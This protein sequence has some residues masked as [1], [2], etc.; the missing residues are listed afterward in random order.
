MFVF[1]PEETF[2]DK[3]VLPDDIYLARTGAIEGV[4]SQ[5]EEAYNWGAEGEKKSGWKQ[6][7]YD[8]L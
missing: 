6:R 2:V 3:A 8:M 4:A 5:D 1:R 7:M